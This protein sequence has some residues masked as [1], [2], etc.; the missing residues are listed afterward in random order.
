L[1]KQLSVRPSSLI[2]IDDPYVAFCFD[3]ACMMWLNHVENRVYET[4]Q[5][6]KN[7]AHR[8]MARMGTLRMLLRVDV[9][10]GEDNTPKKGA[11]R[12]PAA[13]FK[14]KV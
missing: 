2:D 8:Q 13:I 9:I 11:F 12:D 10:E 6:I 5:N 14:K 1:S 7:E 4:G 3:Q